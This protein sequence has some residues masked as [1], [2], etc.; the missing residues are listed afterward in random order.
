[1]V[2]DNSQQNEKIRTDYDALHTK[3]AKDVS[4]LDTSLAVEISKV[5]DKTRQEL[6]NLF[7]KQKQVKGNSIEVIAKRKGEYDSAAK[8]LMAMIGNYLEE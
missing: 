7:N 4:A 2:G 6:F 3:L 5:H 8:E 1:M